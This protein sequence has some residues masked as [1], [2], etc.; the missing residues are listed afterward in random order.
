MRK[1]QTVW[2]AALLCGSLTAYGK[3]AGWQWYND[4]V[5]LPDP[6]TTDKSA[7]VRQEP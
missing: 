1:I 3:D 6:K 2:V 5:K 4:P 7:Q